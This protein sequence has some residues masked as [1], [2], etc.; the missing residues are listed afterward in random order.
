VVLT[1]ALLLALSSIAMT[2]VWTDQVDY[3]PGSVVTITGGN[4]ENGAPGYWS[5]ARVKVSVTGLHDP[6]YE[7]TNCQD[8]AVSKDSNWSCMVTLWTD[9]EWVVGLYEYVASS[10]AADGTTVGDGEVG[11][12]GLLIDG[13]KCLPKGDIDHDGIFL[14]RLGGGR[15]D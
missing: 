11:L 6:P 5:S 15:V 10:V 3:S 14:S 7:S 1:M 2:A 9:P 13:N 8:V 12:Q 4:D